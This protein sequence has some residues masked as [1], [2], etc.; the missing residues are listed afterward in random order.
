MSEYQKEFYRKQLLRRQA[1]RA[2]AR[3]TGKWVVTRNKILLVLYAIR[4]LPNAEI[5]RLRVLVVGKARDFAVGET[6]LDFAVHHDP[7]LGG[8]ITSNKLDYPAKQSG[9]KTTKAPEHPPMPARRFTAETVYSNTYVKKVS[10]PLV[11]KLLHFCSLQ[12]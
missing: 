12:C 2:Q 3:D 7:M 10:L 11:V 5:G 4:A 8:N 1:Q 9:T 6:L